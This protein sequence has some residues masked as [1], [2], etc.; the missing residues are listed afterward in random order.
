MKTRIT[1]QEISPK[2]Y[3]GLKTIDDYFHGILEHKLI[4]L[5]KYRVSQINH[6]AF[7]LDMH[8]KEAIHLGEDELRL[9][10]L[11]AWRE[12]SI[13]S[14]EERAALAFAEALTHPTGFGLSDEIYDNLSRFFDKEKIVALTAVVTHINSW[15]RINHAF[16]PESGKYQVGQFK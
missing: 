6:C 16:R 9:H 4:E 2:I 1:F 12:T 15:N 7:C 10:L 3:A 13:Y 5:I 11:P 8:H 14:E